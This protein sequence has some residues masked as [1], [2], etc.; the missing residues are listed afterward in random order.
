M[1][2]KLKEH[3]ELKRQV[4]KMV[5]S[6]NQLNTKSVSYMAISLSEN[7][8]GTL[9]SNVSIAPNGFVCA[10]IP[11]CSEFGLDYSKIELEI[12][13]LQSSKKTNR[14]QR[15]QTLNM[16]RVFHRGSNKTLEQQIL[17]QTA[18]AAPMYPIPVLL[19]NDLSLP[20]DSLYGD[21]VI[22]P[23]VRVY[24]NK[25][26][27]VGTILLDPESMSNI[28]IETIGLSF[29]DSPSITCVLDEII[30]ITTKHIINVFITKYNTIDIT[31]NLYLD[32]VR[33]LN[34]SYYGN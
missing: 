14:T 4:Y 28:I 3:P 2:L 5:A 27:L 10:S 21:C 17:D 11:V 23:L 22:Q 20:K 12:R 16:T 34:Y 29:L 13:F 32:I 9:F 19:L 30:D 33:Y 31:Q 8:I 7:V 26:K 15:S 18:I 1:E 6:Y 24:F 25:P